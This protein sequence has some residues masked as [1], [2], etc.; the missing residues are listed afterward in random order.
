MASDTKHQLTEFVI[1]RA[2]EP[3]MRAR[4]DGRPD[5]DRKMLQHLQQATRAEIERYRHYRSAAEVI[6][7]FKRDLTSEPAKKV[8]SQLRRLRLPT[9]EDIKDEFESKARDL[10]APGH[11]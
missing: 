1:D 6:T 3:V 7:N 2:F 8:H 9:L 5:A 10:G 11:H 4:S